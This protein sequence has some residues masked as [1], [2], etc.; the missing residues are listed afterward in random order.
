MSADS[1]RRN[2][3]TSS[4]TPERGAL[5]LGG[6]I[7]LSATDY[8]GRL[9]AVLFCQGCTWRC[10]YCHNPHLIPVDGGPGPDWLHVLEFL[11][12]RVGLLDA[13]VFS[14]G[15]PTLQPGLAEAMREVKRLGFSIGLHSAGPRPDRLEPL[16]PLLDW[17]GLDIKAPFARYGELSGAAGSGA[18]VR[19]SL[20]RLVASG[21]DH[22][23][24]TTVHPSLFSARELAELSR[25]LFS[26]GA[27]R[28]VL[29]AFRATGCRDEQL[30]AALDEPAL[31]ALLAEAASLSPRTLTRA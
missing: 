27:R 7:P 14:G 26:L 28:H 22:E 21:V 10:A 20:R 29:Q 25:S 31:T 12:R 30:S 17:V 1:S 11:S 24:R 4:S 18:A 15:E 6:L 13:V 8:P 23:C 9:S 2:P 16:L 5:R 19:E 3:P